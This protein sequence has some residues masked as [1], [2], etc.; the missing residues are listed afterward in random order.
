[1]GGSSAHPRQRKLSPPERRP[2]PRQHTA[3]PGQGPNRT[4]RDRPPLLPAAAVASRVR[5]PPGAAACPARPRAPGGARVRHRDLAGGGTGSASARPAEPRGLAAR[6]EL[7]V[8]R[9]PRG[10]RPAPGERS[11]GLSSARATGSPEHRESGEAGRHPTPCPTSGGSKKLQPSQ[12]HRLPA[13]APEVAGRGLR[14]DRTGSLRKKN[15]KPRR[16]LLAAPCADSRARG[17]DWAA[18][19]HWRGARPEGG[20]RE[21]QA[22]P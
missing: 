11:R 1:M 14:R 18:V 13:A 22:L 2:H 20:P 6:P 3:E 4:R 7:P 17:P 10:S 19:A 16:T 8:S 5:L 9:R 12:P 21:G 15:S